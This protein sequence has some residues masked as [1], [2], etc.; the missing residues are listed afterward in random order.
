[1]ELEIYE[2]E[3]S[4]EKIVRLSLS[5]TVFGITLSVVDEYGEI[6]KDGNLISIKSDGTLHRHTGINE[7]Q[8]FKLDDRGRIKIHNDEDNDQ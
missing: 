5:H 6:I 2:E 1:M 4:K 3:E 7:E 8:D